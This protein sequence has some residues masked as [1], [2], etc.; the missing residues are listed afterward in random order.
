MSKKLKILNEKEIF[1]PEVLYYKEPRK[2]RT[3]KFSSRKKM[4]FEKMFMIK[5]VKG[6]VI[7]VL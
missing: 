7:R 4:I 1:I 5:L 6:T 3:Y 2:D